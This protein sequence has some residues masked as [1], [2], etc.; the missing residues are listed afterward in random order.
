MEAKEYDNICKF[1]QDGSILPQLPTSNARWNFKRKA[2][3]FF[4]KAE[5]L[6][7]TVNID[8]NL[9]QVKF[10]R[11]EELA[12]V[13]HMFHDQVGHPGMNATSTSIQKHYMWKGMHAEIIE[14]VKMCD[15]CQQTASLPPQPQKKL[16]PIPPPDYPWVHIGMDL[17][18]DL[19]MTTEGY[20][21][22][23]VT[24][25]YLSKYVLAR[26]P[27]DED[28]RGGYNGAPRYLP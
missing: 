11:R 22:I 12:E 2:T 8:G 16:H 26:P 14:Y 6:Y 3:K 17:V 9:S 25:C 24:V 20:K 4:I 1:L 28:F 21:H 13:L 15:V 18:C 19:P 27:E 23:L 5:T 7:K 10:P